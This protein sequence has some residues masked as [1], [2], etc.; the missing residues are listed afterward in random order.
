MKG[1]TSDYYEKVFQGKKFLPGDHIV[2][3]CVKNAAPPR[4]LI[5][6]CKIYTRH[7]IFVGRD[8]IHEVVAFTRGKDNTITASY[9]TLAKFADHKPVL[10]AKYE[11]E[12]SVDLKSTNFT[13]EDER[14]PRLE[15]VEFAIR[16]AEEKSLKSS[17]FFGN[18]GE[19]IAHACVVGSRG[20]TSTYLYRALLDEAIQV[21]TDNGLQI[22]WG[23]VCANFSKLVQ[24][25]TEAIWKAGQMISNLVSF[26]EAYCSFHSIDETLGSELTKC[27][28]ELAGNKDDTKVF[29]EH[30]KRVK[31]IASKLNCVPLVFFERVSQ[32]IGDEKFLAKY[33]NETLLD[34]KE[35]MDLKMQ[36][37]HF[38]LAVSVILLT[39]YYE[40]KYSFKTENVKKSETKG[41][42]TELSKMSL[43]EVFPF[44]VANGYSG[45]VTL[46]PSQT[47]VK[48]KENLNVSS[49][50]VVSS[51]SRIF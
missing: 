10:I 23:N 15:T 2:G 28:L 19:S 3:A 7:A 22:L 42:P 17:Y 40:K 32:G 12:T 45:D 24:A 38:L 9:T 41:Q 4:N 36:V 1:A 35:K 44:R 8:P 18:H 21:K 51:K 5:E 6:F 20:P 37:V 50:S 33:V 49:T 48:G 13:Y 34:S 46:K 39:S 29:S 43:K 11:A 14:A 16:L 25:G 27:F 31:K 30:L 26:S 47:Q